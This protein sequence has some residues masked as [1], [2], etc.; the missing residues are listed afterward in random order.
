M[1]SQPPITRI[2]FRPTAS[3]RT[4]ADDFK[5]LSIAL[6]PI[7][8]ASARADKTRLARERPRRSNV[9]HAYVGDWC[10]M[11]YQPR[12]A[13]SPPTPAIDCHSRRWTFPSSVC[14]MHHPA[15]PLSPIPDARTHPRAPPAHAHATPR[16]HAL[17][18]TNA[19]LVFPLRWVRDVHPTFPQATPRT[20]RAGEQP[21]ASRLSIHS[22]YRATRTRHP[23]PPKKNTSL[24]GKAG[25]RHP[26][27]TIYR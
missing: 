17:R 24:A 18:A 3:P 12:P 11:F 9:A 16:C 21:R 14:T 6:L 1:Y 25:G 23:A 7:F 10:S 4:L 2:K 26:Q 5:C 22:L 8:F 19:E 15:P 20:S 27:G 13:P